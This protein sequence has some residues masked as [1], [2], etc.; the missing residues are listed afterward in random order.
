M[1]KSVK[2]ILPVASLLLFTVASVLCIVGLY[3]TYEMIYLFE[4]IPCSFGALA[5]V[6]ATIE[7]FSSPIE[8][9]NKPKG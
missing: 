3:H 9:I 7:T 4:L 6:G 2:K 5:S 1:K 8:T